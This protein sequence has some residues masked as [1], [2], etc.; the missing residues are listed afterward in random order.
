MFVIYQ[1][2]VVWKNRTLSNYFVSINRRNMKN[3]FRPQEK[4]C[5][6]SENL[7]LEKN[8]ESS[9]GL[10]IIPGI[11]SGPFASP[12][13]EVVE[14]VSNEYSVVRINAWEDAEDLEEMTLKDL[15]DLIDEACELLSN[16]GC[17]SISVLGKSFGG[18]LALTYPDNH[19]FEKMVLWAPAAGFGENNV[20]KWRSTLLKHAQTATEISVDEAYLENIDSEVKIIHGTE[21]VVVDVDN[22]RKICQALPKCEFQEIESAGHSFNS[23][24]K[25][26][27]GLTVEF[28]LS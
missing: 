2:N 12:F 21:D 5:N 14:E 20:E 28:L 11:S 16:N 27:A 8:P 15:H 6:M 13:D 1:H 22:S 18:Q 23:F 3:F 10:V 4:N 26:V 25:D 7:A 17:E 19:N 9:R 24:E